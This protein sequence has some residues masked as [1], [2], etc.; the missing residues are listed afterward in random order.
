MKMNVCG[1]FEQSEFDYFVVKTCSARGSEGKSLWNCW[2]RA[3]LSWF[4]VSGLRWKGTRREKVEKIHMLE[5]VG[6][7]TQSRFERKGMRC[8]I[9]QEPAMCSDWREVSPSRRQT[10]DWKWIY[11]LGAV[12]VCAGRKVCIK[13]LQVGYMFLSCFALILCQPSRQVCVG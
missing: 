13:Y 10:T 12:C 2:K 7:F 3:S 4:P 1:W 8:V 5:I 9:R 6:E 11:T